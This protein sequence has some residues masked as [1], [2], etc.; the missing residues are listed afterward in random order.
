MV[1]W[2]VSLLKLIGENLTFVSLVLLAE[3]NYDMYAEGRMTPD[4]FIDEDFE[5]ELG[6]SEKVRLRL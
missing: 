5:R 4:G 2:G 1:L 3:Y 6:W